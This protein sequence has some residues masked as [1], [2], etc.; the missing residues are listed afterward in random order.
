MNTI[1]FTKTLDANTARE[2]CELAGKRFFRSK[3][4]EL[5]LDIYIF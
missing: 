4:K 2:Y 5:K 3:Y 1:H